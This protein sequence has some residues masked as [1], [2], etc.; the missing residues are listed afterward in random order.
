MIDHKNVNASN[1]DAPQRQLGTHAP[2]WIDRLINAINRLP[3]SGW[4]VYPLVLVV[5]LIVLQSIT[6]L[7]GSV[8]W[9]HFTPI[10]QLTAVWTVLPVAVIH[11]LDGGAERTLGLLRP[12]LSLDDDQFDQLVY[13]FTNMPSRRVILANVLGLGSIWVL[14]LASPFLMD[15]AH[16][17]ALHTG[18]A[19]AFGE[20]QLRLAGRHGVPHDP[21]ALAGDPNVR[22]GQGH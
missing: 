19:L 2:S 3:G 17:S 20:R 6:W 21:S 15:R 1:G 14:L 8:Q 7:D 9:G 4:Y 5:E 13:R 12:C 10:E 22:Y 16:S 11:Y 18:A